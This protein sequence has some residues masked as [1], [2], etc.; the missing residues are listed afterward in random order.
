MIGDDD[1]RAGVAAGIVT[2]AQA[3]RLLT[4]A[5]SRAGTRA[6]L[7][8][9]DEPFELFR[10]F[11]EI[12]ISVGLVILISGIMGVVSLSGHVLAISVAGAGL[13]VLLALYFTRKR[14]MTLPSI[15]LSIAFGQSVAVAVVFLVLGS[16]DA[17]PGTGAVYLIGAL[18]VAALAAW[19][20]LF[21]IPFTMF[22]IGVA[23]LVTIMMAISRAAPIA[24]WNNPANLFDL[25]GGS[26][27]AR[28][29]LGFGIAAFIAGMW[30]DT[31]DP[32]RLGRYAASGFWLHLLA[33]PAL[34]NTVALSFLNMGSGTGYT[35]LA[36]SL[37]LITLLALIIDRRSFLTAGI[38]YL[39]IL[40]GLVLVP[41]G[42]SPIRWA[43]LLIVLGS[44]VTLTGAFWTQWRSAILRALP[45]FPG[46]NRLPPYGA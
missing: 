34:V 39:G 10:G 25:T 18:I 29:T 13:A 4:L 32:H 1:L 41:D 28:G 23:V 35:L 30:F 40:L 45:A 26:L 31:R 9:D 36:V 43:W 27:L 7:T 33:A 15:I 20:W 21:K 19:Y 38:A 37:A 6:A 8:G 22:L 44:F 11:S 17:I 14:R 24:L 46:K 3:S 2:E 42:G 12:F 16:A 5:Q